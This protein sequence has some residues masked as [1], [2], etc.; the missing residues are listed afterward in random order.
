MKAFAWLTKLAKPFRSLS[1]R[2]TGLY[3]T[4]F[5]LYC[6]R[7][8]RAMPKFRWGGGE[9]PLIPY[10]HFYILAIYSKTIFPVW[11]ISVCKTRPSFSVKISYHFSTLKIITSVDNSYQLAIVILKVLH[12]CLTLIIHVLWSAQQLVYNGICYKWVVC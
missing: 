1:Y 12:H 4:M 6:I 9:I 5:M 3:L 11:L 2:G 8:Y 10:L 7:I